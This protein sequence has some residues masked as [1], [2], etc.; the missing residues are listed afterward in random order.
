MKS[1][2]LSVLWIG[3]I[4]EWSQFTPLD[5]SFTVL[6]PGQPS[7]FENEMESDIGMIKVESYH[8][9][10]GVG[11]NEQIFSINKSNYP[12]TLEFNVQDSLFQEIESIT[13]E[14]ILNPLNGKIL[15]HESVKIGNS[16]AKVFLIQYNDT[17]AI[18]TYL[19]PHHNSVYTI[20]IF[21]SYINRNSRDAEKMISSFKILK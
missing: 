7:Y 2:L 14:G 8:S 21:S 15:Y 12:S 11:K 6:L 10:V 5:Q 9:S 4:T 3:W 1:I 20:Q 17:E 16:D 13:K 18:K 19:I